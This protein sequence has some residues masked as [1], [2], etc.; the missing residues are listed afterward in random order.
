M[1]Q[2]AREGYPFIVFFSSITILTAIF[3]MN[4][5]TVVPLILTAFMFYF[6]RDPDRVTVQNKNVF[7]SPAD[8]KVILITETKEDEM[9]QKHALKI[10]IFMS[11]LNV[12]VNRVP[13]DGIVKEVKYY[14]GKFFS[15]FKDDASIL[16]EHITM[17]FES[18]QH[19]QLVVKQIAGSVAR[20]AVCR[21]KPGDI[22]TQ[23]QRYGI[24]KFSSR[25]DIFLPLNTH[26]QVKL[27]DKVK[28]GETII[29][30]S[31]KHLADS[32]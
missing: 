11:P 29:A 8:G 7:Y 13:C 32:N 22:L 4:W 19:G 26:V 20:R 27:N 18:E 5:V 1:F 25:V 14:P 6:F 9:L 21:A 16:N 15:A 17:L 10:S 2:F 23:G 30:V 12:H 28:A 24:I 31:S 3:K